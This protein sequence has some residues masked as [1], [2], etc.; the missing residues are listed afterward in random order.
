MAANPKALVVYWS[1]TGNTEKVA[2]AIFHALETEGA[3]AKL[4]KM[5]DAADEDFHDYDLIFLGAPSYQFL[6]PKPVLDFL[7]DI[8]LRH[9]QATP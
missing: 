3:T 1:A 9:S 7:N 5:G 8:L 4:L 6:P 2:Q